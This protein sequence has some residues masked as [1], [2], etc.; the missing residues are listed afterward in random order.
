MRRKQIDALHKMML[1][2]LK[3]ERLLS[4]VN[5]IGKE[6]F[7]AESELKI[8][9]LAIKQDLQTNFKVGNIRILNPNQNGLLKLFDIRSGA[10]F[11]VGLS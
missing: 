3:Q 1:Q 6:F 9:I 7:I 11:M 2:E 5:M 4:F 8:A 10:H